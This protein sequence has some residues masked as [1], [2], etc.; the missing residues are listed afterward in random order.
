MLPRVPLLANPSVDAR[1]VYKATTRQDYG[2]LT[3]RYDQKSFA[4]SSRETHSAI[5]VA[6]QP[7][8][9]PPDYP[10]PSHGQGDNTPASKPSRRRNPIGICPRHGV[11]VA[12]ANVLPGSDNPPRGTFLAT[13]HRYRKEHFVAARFFR[14][15]FARGSA[16]NR[17]R[18][19]CSPTR[20]RTTKPPS[21]TSLSRWCP[22][23]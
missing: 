8:A 1:L 23:R 11:L 15:P 17:R 20:C 18:G 16:T 10:S 22:P 9:M 7:S 19:C 2:G 4:N 13:F 5:F 6:R 12:K 14:A 21:R 3:P